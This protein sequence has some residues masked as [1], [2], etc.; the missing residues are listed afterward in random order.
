MQKVT[1]SAKYEILKWIVPNKE[2]YCEEFRHVKNWI[3]PTP[4][5]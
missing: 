4:G 5:T 1:R 3:N 2:A